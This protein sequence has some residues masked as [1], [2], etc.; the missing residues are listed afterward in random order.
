MENLLKFVTSGNTIVGDLYYLMRSPDVQAKVDTQIEKVRDAVI[1]HASP[2]KNGEISDISK[3]IQPVLKKIENVIDFTRYFA[4]HAGKPLLIFTLLIIAVYH[5]TRL[6][7]VAALVYF[8][9]S[10]FFCLVYFDVT[11]IASAS[12]DLK[13]LLDHTMEN[14]KHPS[15]EVRANLTLNNVQLTIGKIERLQGN[16]FLF[17]M[18]LHAPLESIL[19]HLRSVE[20]SLAVVNKTKMS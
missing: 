2:K 11:Q 7:S 16:L 3:E 18:P 6:I 10:G 12:E 9:I 8:I 5:F 15:Q 1:E 14:M 20:K 17:Q 19:N 13:D 4:K